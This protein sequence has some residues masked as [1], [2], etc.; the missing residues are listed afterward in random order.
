MTLL[1]YS[2]VRRF[3]L[4]YRTS[5]TAPRLLWAFENQRKKNQIKKVSTDCAPFG[6]QGILRFW[7]RAC[8]EDHTEIQFDAFLRHW[9]SGSG[10]FKNELIG[11]MS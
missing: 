4:T 9:Q 3:A 6:A 2:E 10:I 1:V 8:P 11:F 7:I 5:F